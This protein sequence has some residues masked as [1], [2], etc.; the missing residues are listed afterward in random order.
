VP[1]QLRPYRDLLRRSEGCEEG[2]RSVTGLLVRANKTA[3]GI[4]AAQ[5]G[6]GNKAG[7]RA[8]PDAVFEAGWEAEA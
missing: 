2:S 3:Q 6:E 5:V 7:D 4:D 1:R 8:R